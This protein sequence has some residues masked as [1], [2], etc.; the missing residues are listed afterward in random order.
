MF[1][2]WFRKRIFFWLVLIT[3]IGTSIFGY[4]KII[5]T[6]ENMNGLKMRVNLWSIVIHDIA[7]RPFGRGLDS[8]AKPVI[9]GQYRYYWKNNTKEIVKILIKKDKT[10]DIKGSLKYTEINNISFAD[11][12][13]NEYL[14]L[15]FTVGV[16]SMIP[17]IFILYFIWRRFKFSRHDNFSVGFTSYFICIG[18]MCMTQFYFHLA[19]V[20]HMFPIALAMF[21]IAT[22]DDVD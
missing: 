13:H 5:K 20:V 15:L 8:F 11:H 1:F 16:F 2:L 12:P 4:N 22:E 9:E 10:L 14:Y 19:R 21:Y 18:I 6:A 7:E 17:L 3:L